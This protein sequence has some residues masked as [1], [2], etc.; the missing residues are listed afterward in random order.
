M[1][2]RRL[3]VVAVL[4]VAL[5]GCT[6]SGDMT[7]T[8]AGPGEVVELTGVDTLKAAFAEGEGKPRLL[9]LLSPT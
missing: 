6:N 3:G 2:P 9:L 5:A 8:G 4:A 1:L 7:G